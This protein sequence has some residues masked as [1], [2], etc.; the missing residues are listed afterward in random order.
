MNKSALELRK[1]PEGRKH[2]ES[3]QKKFAL[4]ILQ[5]SDPKFDKVYAQKNK[6]RARERELADKKAK[7]YNEEIKARTKWDVAKGYRR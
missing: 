6:Q 2:L 7:T 5:P 3:Q 4:D 1:T